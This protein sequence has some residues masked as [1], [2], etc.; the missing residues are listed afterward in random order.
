M[1]NYRFPASSSDGFHALRSFG[2]CALMNDE[3][4]V[5]IYRDGYCETDRLDLDEQNFPQSI[6]FVF[7]G[8]ELKEHLS[9]S[10]YRDVV[11]IN[12]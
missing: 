2:E 8:C 10:K 3:E 7:P 11:N 6:K 4:N 9:Y 5:I 1:D 12:R